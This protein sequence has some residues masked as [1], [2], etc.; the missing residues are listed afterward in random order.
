MNP[1]QLALLRNSLRALNPTSSRRRHQNLNLRQS[2][3][4][5]GSRPRLRSHPCRRHGLLQI[6]LSNLN[7]GHLLSDVGVQGG[8]LEFESFAMFALVVSHSD[9]MCSHMFLASWGL[10][11]FLNTVA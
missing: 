11:Q 8:E 3:Q 9:H 2:D 5:L 10:I 7:S 6:S 4:Q 1:N